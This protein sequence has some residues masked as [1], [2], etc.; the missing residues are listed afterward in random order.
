MNEIL[1]RLGPFLFIRVIIASWNEILI[2][3][4]L[5]ILLLGLYR[6]RIKKQKLNRAL[7]MTREIIVFDICVLIYNL[8]HI[9]STLLT[10]I[11][12]PVA[13]FLMH[14]SAFCYYAAGE[15]HS[16]F[17]LYIFQKKIVNELQDK[18][19]RYLTWMFGFLQIPLLVML[20]ASPFAGMLYQ[21]QAYHL[22]RD[23]LGV[24]IWLSATMLTMLYM[25]AMLII[26]WK[27]S[28][29]VFCKTMAAAIFVPTIGML[30]S[31]LT[32][33]HL[34]D[35]LAPVAIIIIFMLHM[36]YKSQVA[37]NN[38][39]E[40]ARTRELLAES[41]FAL[42]HSKNQ[43]LIAQIQPHFINNSLMTLAARCVDYPDIYESIM[44]FSLYLRSHFD[45]LGDDRNITFEQEMENIEAYLALA[46]ESYHE[47]LQVEYEIECD[48][49]LVP[50][51][52]VQPLVEN[53]VQHG[54]SMYDEGGTVTISASCRNGTVVIEVTDEGRGS[55]SLTAQQNKRKGIGVENVRARLRS[56]SDGKMEL[57]QHEN[58]TTARITITR[59]EK[60]EANV[61][62]NI[63]CGRS[64]AD[65]GADAPAA[66]K[67]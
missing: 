12:T 49:F 14:C 51:L 7:P 3:F 15:F 41:H 65:H 10:G 24:H 67:D 57:I 39:N 53:A 50:A 21:V 18:T 44:N 4:L 32:G 16:L 47:K 11:E 64:A 19:L 25:G 6:D 58:G 46:K 17:L 45:A 59:C 38:A 26:H 13:G 30:V 66:D 23:T 37:I 61:N 33:H 60:K 34:T 1:D 22:N 42:E 31:F 35:E 54:V 56:M 9:V 55:S 43:T 40:L 62:D 63:V 20:L 8:S 36:H 27:K 28:K 48:D 52:S 5:L 2:L 29:P